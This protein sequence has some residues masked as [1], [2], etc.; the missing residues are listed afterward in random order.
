MCVV[1]GLIYLLIGALFG[2][3]LAWLLSVGLGPDS[4]PD[5]NAIGAEAAHPSTMEER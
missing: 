1:V 4:A 3:A 5:D 2:A